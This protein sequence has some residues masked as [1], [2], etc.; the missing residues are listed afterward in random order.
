MNDNIIVNR[1]DIPYKNINQQEIA[2]IE[3]YI[4]NYLYIY[5]EDFDDDLNKLP[6]NI[7][8]LGFYSKNCNLKYL[9]LHI[10]WL[11]L[12]DLQNHYIIPNHIDILYISHRYLQKFPDVLSTISYGLKVLCLEIIQND[13]KDINLDLLPDSIEK[14]IL[15]FDYCNV[16]INLNKIYPNLKQISIYNINNVSN[17]DDINKYCESNNIEILD[18]CLSYEIIFK[19]YISEN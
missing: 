15:S 7:K 4:Y 9:P 14:I 2:H 12:F 19:E 18:T 17:I 5:N 1:F 10:K 3:K 11:N 16:F 6:S 13:I 8:I